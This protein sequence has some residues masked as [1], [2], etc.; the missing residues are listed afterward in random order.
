MESDDLIKLSQDVKYPSGNKYLAQLQEYIHSVTDD[1]GI[2]YGL[3]WSIGNFELLYKD[4]TRYIAPKRMVVLKF[5]SSFKEEYYEPSSE[6]RIMENPQIFDKYKYDSINIDKLFNEKVV[7][8]GRGNSYVD[9]KGN[10]YL[11]G[12]KS[13]DYNRIPVVNYYNVEVQNPIFFLIKLENH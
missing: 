8:I 13:N 3:A 6:L 12:I 2:Y 7:C 1:N 10:I 4:G 11:T 5:D 9:K